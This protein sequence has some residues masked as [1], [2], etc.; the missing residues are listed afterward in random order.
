MIHREGILN[1]TPSNS[2]KHFQNTP[3]RSQCRVFI[4]SGVGNDVGKIVGGD[5]GVSRIG[6][7]VGEGIKVTLGVVA[8]VTFTGDENGLGLSDETNGL[9]SAI[10]VG[11]TVLQAPHSIMMRTKDQS[12]FPIS[13]LALFLAMPRAARRPR[14]EPPAG[15]GCTG[16]SLRQPGGQ[17]KC[18]FGAARQVGFSDG[19]ATRKPSVHPDEMI[20]RKTENI[21]S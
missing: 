6:V 9:V 17:R 8:G 15:A 12:L 13:N 18:P 10:C 2:S 7:F 4:V 5:V 16:F 1:P 11:C 19:C 21:N 20:Y 3:S 14:G